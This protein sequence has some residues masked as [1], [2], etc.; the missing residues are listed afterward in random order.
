MVSGIVIE[1][2]TTREKNNIYIPFA[3]SSL[4][5]APILGSMVEK[6]WPDMVCPAVFRAPKQIEYGHATNCVC[7]HEVHA[8]ANAIATQQRSSFVSTNSNSFHCWCW[9]MLLLLILAVDFLHLFRNFR[10]VPS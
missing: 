6:C 5:V 10:C 8:H 2:Q 7:T 4:S 1:Q 3:G 9:Y